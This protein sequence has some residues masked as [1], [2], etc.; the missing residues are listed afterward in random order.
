MKKNFLATLSLSLAAA[1]A[2]ALAASASA[3]DLRF[4]LPVM[5]SWTLSPSNSVTLAWE[6]SSPAPARVE[7]APIHATNPP[8]TLEQPQPLRRHVFTLTRLAPATTYTYTVS[9]NTGF[10]QHGRFRTAPASTLTPFRFILTSDLQGGLDFYA[11]QNVANAIARAAP[12]FITSAG[13]LSDYRYAP[14]YPAAIHSWQLFFNAC[15]NM[16]ASAVFQPVTGNHDEPENPDSLWFRML[17]L[18]GNKRNFTFDVGPI[19]FIGIDNAEFEVPAQAP[20]LARELQRAAANPN[21]RFVIPI[22]HRPPYSWGQRGGQDVVRLWFSPLFTRY[23]ASLVLSGHAHTYQRISPIRGVPYLV[24]GGNGGHL[25][26]VDPSRPEIAFA[27]S[28]YH[29]VEFAWNP[30]NNTLSLH[31]CNTN[32][33]PFDSTTFTPFRAVHFSPTFP[34][35]GQPCT[36]TY[37]PSQGPLVHAPHVSLH[38]GLDEFHSPTFTRPMT[39]L[40]NGLFTL[41]FTVPLE[42]KW[43]LAFCFCDP[44]RQLWDNNHGLN[45]HLLLQRDW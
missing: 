3:A 20:W 34:V 26:T 27:T 36:I 14:D 23:E 21:L 10:S 11:A 5:A 43:N 25:Y 17:E 19:R 24:S 44:S 32:N 6:R 7:Y 42:P 8:A 4:D 16:L 9:D 40:P 33:I 2:L 12:D 37:D 35:R 29:Y 38:L 15:S 28:C 39:R 30:T 1:A 41:T 18:P 22:C 45:W 13:D 31:A